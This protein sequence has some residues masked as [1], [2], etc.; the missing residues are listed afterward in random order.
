MAIGQAR[1]SIDIISHCGLSGWAA[2]NGQGPLQLVTHQG[3]GDLVHVVT[4]ACPPQ[5]QRITGCPIGLDHLGHLGVPVKRVNGV[6]QLLYNSHITDALVVNREDLV[7]GHGDTDDD[8][9]DDSQPYYQLYQG[10]ALLVFMRSSN[11]GFNL[12]SP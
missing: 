6:L 9:G 5:H 7:K 10:K 2:V 3:V 11:Y 4:P 12:S 1:V 8:E